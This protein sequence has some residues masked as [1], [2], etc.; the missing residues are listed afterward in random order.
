LT[1]ILIASALC[2]TALPGSE[3]Y[4]AARHAEAQGRYADAARHY[5]AAAEQ[6]ELLR[7]F[8]LVRGARSLVLAGDDER[9][10]TQLE[11]FA[12]ND[13]LGPAQRLA[14]V[15]LASRYKRS[16]RPGDAAALLR[17]AVD[18]PVPPRFLWPYR[19]ELVD[20]L[21]ATKAGKTEGY[22][23][24]AKMVLEART[25]AHR[26][27]AAERL[28]NSPDLQ[29][30]LDAA[31]AFLYS[32]EDRAAK[33]ALVAV[34]PRL[35]LHGNA[36]RPQSLYLQGRLQLGAKD[37]SGRIILREV[38][39]NHPDSPWAAAA[40]RYLGRDL[41]SAGQLDAA[42]SAFDRLADAYAGMDE[43]ARGLW[44]YA[45]RLAS[46][47]AE[48]GAA[49]VYER[50][51]EV[52]PDQTLAD[53]AL[54]EAGRLLRD[55][56]KAE[57]AIRVYQALASCQPN[58]PMTAEALFESGRLKESRGDTEGAVSDYGTAA[59]LVGQYHAH[60]AVERLHELGKIAA[61]DLNATG[62]NSFVRPLPLGELP[63]A[64]YP[65]TI[66]LTPWFQ[67]LKFFAGNG[68]EE[69]EWEGVGLIPNLAA[70][71][72]GGPYYAALS[73]AGLM[74][75]AAEVAEATGWGL[76]DGAP[77]LERLRVLYPR[78]YWDE[79]QRMA[80]ETGLD[81][82]LILAVGRQESIFQSRVVSSAGATGVMQLMPA[83]AKWLAGIEPAVS[84]DQL[85]NLTHPENSLRLGAY[86]LIRM[87][88]RNDSNLVYALASYN[89]GPGNVSKWKRQI[90]TSD[91]EAFVEA[92]PF[93]ETR[94]FVKKVLGNYAA[95]HSI[96][97]E[98]SRIALAR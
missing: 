69:A 74:A 58:G 42:K 8:A 21:I 20:C 41:H 2:V 13:S 39:E 11:R 29:H 84:N 59:R 63:D 52:C 44:W 65:D 43:T 85:E 96:Y 95:Y 6:D 76:K 23:L 80:R 55:A 91:M 94:G 26:L 64:V 70:A 4:L 79:V 97:P 77:T 83:T 14:Q 19:L 92:I 93:T 98:P 78:A 32:G 71:A 66:T 1:L 25:R 16:G 47:G 22:A 62:K 87:V 24:C 33:Q 12:T 28:K 38:A 89:A 48:T 37:G 17:K 31:E 88:E 90:P 40:L 7:P 50:L 68:L 45:G 49:A 46:E 18:V 81:P 57:A 54:I 73:D 36:Y 35:L 61:R 51:A 30:V 75:M 72:D 67:R 56:K 27:E 60:R 34:A 15:E 5:A 10:I 53:D 3:S 86:Y 82:Y 9:A